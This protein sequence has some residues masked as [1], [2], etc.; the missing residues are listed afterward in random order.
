M[1]NFEFEHDGQKLWYSRSLACNLIVFVKHKN[2]QFSVLANKRGQGCE[3]NKGRWN[4]PGGFIDFD[5][6]AVQ[7]AIRECREECGVEIKRERVR[8]FSLMTKPNGGRQTMVAIHYAVFD[9][10]ETKEWDFMPLTCE[11]GEVDEVRMIPL[12]DLNEYKWCYN[13]TSMIMNTYFYG[14]IG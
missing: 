1:K 12:E 8:F 3:F 2:G 11:P 10:D 5:E 14:V 13:Q 7:C 6:D 4:V 9:E